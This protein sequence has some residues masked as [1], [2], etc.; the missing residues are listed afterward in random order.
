MSEQ[1]EFEPMMTEEEILVVTH[2]TSAEA[3]YSQRAQAL[4]AI[5][6]GK[7]ADEAGEA[8]GLRA[9]Q[10]KY[11]VSRYRKSGLAIFP[12][13]LLVEEGEDVVVETAVSLEKSLPSNT[14]QAPAEQKSQ[15]KKKE[16]KGKKSKEVKGK[17]SVATTAEQAP[18]DKKDKKKKSK[19][20]QKKR[21]T[22]QAKKQKKDKKTG[23]KKKKDKKS[24]KEKKTKKQKKDKS[25]KKKN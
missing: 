14:E 12:E 25:T 10:V 21:K 23:K 11:W 24:K 18:S 1:K 13:E 22:K 20:K 19:D 4:L 8:S 5:N 7:T 9:T 3:P 6:H 2:I 15:E 17:K 16:Q